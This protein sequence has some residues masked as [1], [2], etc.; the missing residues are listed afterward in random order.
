MKSITMMFLIVMIV[1]GASL[2][3]TVKRSINNDP[4]LKALKKDLLMSR[5]DTGIVSASY[6][7]NA[8]LSAFAGDEFTQTPAN[9]QN[10]KY[11]LIHGI[12]ITGNYNLYSGHKNEFEIKEKLEYEKLARLKLVDKKISIAKETAIYYIEVLKR[13][14]IY[15][16]YV[17]SVN[18]YKRLIKKISKKVEEGGG[19]ESDLIQTKSR[20]KY[21]Q[22][23]MLIAKQ[24]YLQALLLLSKYTGVRPN[25]KTMKLPKLQKLPSLNYLLNR[26]KKYNTSIGSLIL[27][28]NISSH[29]IEVQ[30]S[31]LYPTI[32]IEGLGNISYNEYGI[33]G[34]NKNARI[35]I[36]AKYRLYDSG[37]TKLSIEKA[38]LQSL[39][40]G[41][42]IRDA[43]REV[44]NNIKILYN[45]YDLYRDRIK[46]I[47][48][49]IRYAKEAEVLYIK[50]EEE[51]GERSIIDILN[52]Q[53]EYST[54]KIAKIDSKYTAMQIYYDLMGS[55]PDIL[56]M[57]HIS[58]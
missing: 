21:E 30:K 42:S 6:G 26:A 33:D 4:V 22:T 37:A 41:D 17:K 44:L 48:Q 35:T 57:F 45:K 5:M 46:T 10:T 53:K 15:Q 9:E 38:K 1:N 20:M 7:L 18:N 16:E 43:Q 51:T 14:Y 2:Q 49:N 40:M 52:I 36:A 54:A 19:R 47:E 58:K 23:S 55:T 24:E 13:Y 39:K 25:I 27:Q 56:N 12:T 50:E 34:A 31:R 8:N 32:D 3:N 11:S 29:L 28:K